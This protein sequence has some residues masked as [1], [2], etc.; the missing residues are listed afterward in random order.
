MVCNTYTREL[1]LNQKKLD[2]KT[3][4]IAWDV[5]GVLLKYRTQESKAW[6]A[7]H[8]E[9]ANAMDE[10]AK[11]YKLSDTITILE[12]VA[13]DYPALESVA[14]KFKDLSTKAPR[15]DGITHALTQL[16]HAGYPFIIASNMTTKT[17][18]ALLADKSL[19]KEFF[20]K[21]FFFSKNHPFNQKPDGSFAGKPEPFYFENLKKYINLKYPN[22]F[23]TFILVDDEEANIVAAQKVGFKTVHFK[24]VAQMVQELEKLGIQISNQ[25]Q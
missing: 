7:E 5:D 9:L 15:I 12:A 11:K 16:H 21:D 20:S 3:T 8:P 25:K 1:T 22:R 23:T 14:W 4:I 24:S 19:P 13:L 2:P 6:L 10:V 18:E 17:Y